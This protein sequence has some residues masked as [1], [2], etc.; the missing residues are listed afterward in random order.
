L[1]LQYP[2]WHGTRFSPS[3]TG[4]RTQ[5]TITL[6]EDFTQ[7]QISLNDYLS[8][9]HLHQLE[10]QELS[11][12]RKNDLNLIVSRNFGSVGDFRV[13]QRIMALDPT[14]Q[15]YHLFYA[16]DYTPTQI[17]QNNVILIGGWKSNPWVDLFEERMNFV[18]EYDPITSNSS[19]K[20]RAPAAGEHQVYAS[21]HTPQSSV[22]Y[23]IVAYLPNIGQSGKALIIEGTGSQAP[24]AAG[25]FLTSESQFS[26]LEKRLGVRKLPHFEVLLETRLVNNPPLDTKIIAY[27]TFPG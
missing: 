6:I 21:P 16:R 13:A 26:V 3:T 12:D 22:G 14:A 19:I 18:I 4:A 27:R 11:V 24:E 15:K 5:A 23:S 10:A 25:D 1:D 9:S 17:K 20:N 8:R 2:S 7:R